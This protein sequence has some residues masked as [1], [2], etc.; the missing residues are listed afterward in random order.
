[1]KLGPHLKAVS[2]YRVT[3]LL[4]NSLPPATKEG[5]TRGIGNQVAA[6]QRDESGRLDWFVIAIMS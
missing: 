4:S 3:G 5:D 1:M 2:P 6:V